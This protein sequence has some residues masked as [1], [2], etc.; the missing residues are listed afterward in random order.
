VLLPTTHA[1][2]SRTNPIFL[3][4]GFASCPRMLRPL[5]RHLSRRLRREVVSVP[6]CPGRD[7]LRSSARELQ[8]ALVPYT[9]HRD[10]GYADIVAHSMGG[11]TATYLLKALDRGRHVRTVVT[12]GTPHRGTPLARIG[13]LVLGAASRAVWQ[14][15]PGCEFLVQLE[16]LATPAGSRLVSIAGMR[17][18][19]VPLRS[20]RVAS[21]GGQENQALAD[22]NHTDFLLRRSVFAR[23][24]AEL[25]RGASAALP[26]GTGKHASSTP[27]AA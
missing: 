19:I 26:H 14:M 5:E 24:A 4:H 9:S 7:D 27:M 10:F 16:E 1:R 2:N 11:L 20:T 25:A 6:L 23:V 12:L 21:R 13:V 22:V 8:R 15:L 18:W 3:V 17:D